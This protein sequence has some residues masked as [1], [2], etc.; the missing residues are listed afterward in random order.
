M[1][2]TDAQQT[3]IDAQGNVLVLAGA[4]TGKTRTMVSRCIDRLF[5]VDHAVDLDRILMVTFTEAAA[6]EMK[7]RIGNALQ[8]HLE[9]GNQQER[10]EEQI[11]LL[12]SA[13]IGTLHSFAL[14]MIREFSHHL[15]FST[16]LRVLSA[17]E[18][19][20]LADTALNEVFD[21]HYEQRETSSRDLCS[22][23]RQFGE[24]N[25]R[26]LRALVLKIYQYVQ[27]LPQPEFWIQEQVARA[28]QK[29]PS[30]WLSWLQN[31]LPVWC[32]E[33]IQRLDRAS[34]DN[35]NL[36]TVRR[37][38]ESASQS[39]IHDSV[40]ECG[41]I[42]AVVPL[43]ELASHLHV[44]LSADADWPRGHKT[45]FRKPFESLFD[46]LQFLNS[47]LNPSNHDMVSPLEE[48]WER[49]RSWNTSL[50]Q[51]TQEFSEVYTRLKKQ[52]EGV[53]F[54][55]LEQQFLKLLYDSESG[56][57]SPIAS[58]I[59]SRFDYVF[60]DEYQDIN[61]A[62]DAIIRAVSRPGQQ[63]NLFIV[64]DVKQSI[65]RFRRANPG[66]LK[67][68][69]D[70][71]TNPGIDGT[72]VYLQANFR[73]APA[74]LDHINEFCSHLSDLVPGF[75][76]GP[77]AQLE[78]GLQRTN[79]TSD[80]SNV[81]AGARI[82]SHLLMKESFKESELTPL[83]I[84]IHIIAQRIKQFVENQTLFDAEEEVERS[85]RWSDFA[86]LMRSISGKPQVVARIFA[87]YH[88]P[89]QAAEGDF[90]DFPEVVDLLSLLRVIDNPL[91]DIPL[92]ALLR[93]PF[94]GFTDNELALVRLA[95]PKG[96]YWHAL[97]KFA[98]TPEDT[99]ESIVGGDG[100]AS[101]FPREICEN[102]LEKAQ[103]FFQNHQHWLH[104]RKTHSTATL[105]EE[106]LATGFFAE[107]TASLSPTRDPRTNIRQLIQLV[108][109]FEQQPDASLTHFLKWIDELID[110]GHQ[111][112]PIPEES[113]NA[114]QL[115]SIHKSKGLEFPIV[116]LPD[117]SKRF[118]FTDLSQRI[119]IDE[120]LGLCP[121]LN[122][123]NTPQTYPSLSHWLAQREHRKQLI[124]EEARLL[125]VA[126]TRAKEHLILL[127]EASDKQLDESWSSP[128]ENQGKVNT[129]ID[130]IGPW[131]LEKDR[132]QS[133][134]DSDPASLPTSAIILHH[135]VSLPQPDLSPKDREVEEN[136][137]S[138]LTPESIECLNGRFEW[139]YPYE[140]ATTQRAKGSISAFDRLEAAPPLVTQEPTIGSRFDE[141]KPNLP[142]RQQGKRAGLAYHR[143]LQY[144]HPSEGAREQS[145]RRELK[146]L[147]A[148]GVLSDEEIERIEIEKVVAFWTSD[149]GMQ[150]RSQ[151]DRMH[152]ELPF[153]ARFTVKELGK[154]GFAVTEDPASE[155]EPVILQGVVDLAVITKEEIWVLDF[156]SEQMDPSEIELR[157]QSHQAQL[158]VYKS[159][160]EK[161]YQRPVTQLWI[162]F[163]V[164]GITVNLLNS[165]TPQSET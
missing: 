72:R 128:T 124:D 47:L 158:S 126:L 56:D 108:R 136:S 39:L 34:F 91:Q 141:S 1:S 115:M 29:S 97:S 135:E 149:A 151:A 138:K 33:W 60:V 112:E 150:I 32:E 69:E 4:G 5:S 133:D 58:E 43:A 44:A 109:E 98:T 3:A 78:P 10:V 42:P 140:G 113:H 159:A 127:A 73:S 28:Q 31:A 125:Y 20:R 85:F 157:T 144:L 153:T 75:D 86:I 129:Y 12:D 71:W 18:A 81:S 68:Y 52:I 87:M 130:W 117:L 105:L 26:P 119:I 106:I 22:Q 24:G 96:F 121:I 137:N 70:Q 89:V 21:H 84:E 164:P 120:E 93:S 118:N 152:R 122:L 147:A 131:I 79:S 142:R 94:F 160:L 101:A 88:I 36:Q 13:H 74:L 165:Q 111:I 82:E 2:F 123:P 8:Q 65:Y 64:G 146:R 51:L 156:K 162:H 145:V 37:A 59:Q 116:F 83:E 55:D 48:D 67:R 114:V 103:R 49:T 38:L 102:A 19:L 76:Y 61:G 6:S 148:L 161:T 7:Q 80:P 46:D 25:D 163:L 35:E 92:L 27:S 45:K 63:A 107:F 155:S 99:I 139:I 134:I 11:A 66:I 16:G 15:D 40:S 104:A 41:E 14:E 132:Q 17:E 100:N 54:Q 110:G 57:L 90:F 53:D 95:K 50:L 62:Q 23:I 143:V 9:S 154:I 77:N 30:L